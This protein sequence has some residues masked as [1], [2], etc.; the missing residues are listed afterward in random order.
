MKCGRCAGLIVSAYDHELRRE[1]RKCVNCGCDP[2]A[3]V[4]QGSKCKWVHCLEML[5]EPGFCEQHQK[6]RVRSP[7]SKA[8][9]EQRRRERKRLS[10]QRYRARKKAQQAAVQ[11]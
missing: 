9:R 10:V 11:S 1:Y 7:L 3:V 6:S 4:R 8:E 5:A 2:D